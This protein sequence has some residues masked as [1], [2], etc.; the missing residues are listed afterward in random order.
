MTPEKRTWTRIAVAGGLL[1][2]IGE[3]ALSP[4]MD[5]P[6]GT[7]LAIAF[8]VAFLAGATL[9]RR[10]RTGGAGLIAVLAAVELAFMPMYTWSSAR[11]WLA[12][13]SFAIASIIALVGGVGVVALTRRRGR[14]EA[15]LTA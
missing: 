3:L 4:T 1:C 5:F 7:I 2:G 11:D 9:V 10:G 8:G 14:N 15:S 6:S 12:Q 13:G